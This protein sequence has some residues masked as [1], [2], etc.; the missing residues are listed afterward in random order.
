MLR[1]AKL[2]Q[3]AGEE[4]LRSGRKHLP[5]PGER[6]RQDATIGVVVGKFIQS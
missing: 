3:P 6:G 5:L 2:V 4:V 1:D